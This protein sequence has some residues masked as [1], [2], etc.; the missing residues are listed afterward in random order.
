MMEVLSLIDKLAELNIS[1]WVMTLAVVYKFIL[2]NNIFPNIKAANE[3]FVNLLAICI[4]DRCGENIFDSFERIQKIVCRNY[5]INVDL[6]ISYEE[7][8]NRVLYR[9]ISMMKHGDDIFTF[10]D[11]NENI[12]EWARKKILK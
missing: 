6:L 9:N 3:Q 7:A 12:M 4:R 5:S 11:E 10:I 8:V 2:K 1:L